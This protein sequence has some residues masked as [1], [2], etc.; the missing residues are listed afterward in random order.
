MRI[1][2]F[3]L[4]MIAAMFTLSA[5]EEVNLVKNGDFSEGSKGWL[6]LKGATVCTDKAT[7]KNYVC[8]KQGQQAVQNVTVDPKADY[9]L[10]FKAKADNIDK[11]KYGHGARIIIRGGKRFARGTVDPKG[12]C[13]IGSFDWKEG[14]CLLKGSVFSSN[15][16][17][18]TLHLDVDG[19]CCF[20]DFKMV[21]V[22]AEKKAE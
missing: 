7:G 17:V 15:K 16:I 2:T 18:L 6:L 10:T 20:T 4:A 5:A 19:S 13:M 3:I 22:A 1:T 8:I 12:G 14:K 21:K 11:N 9:L